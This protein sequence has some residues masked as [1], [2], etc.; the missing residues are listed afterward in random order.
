MTYDQILTLDFIVKYGS[1]KAAA[2][3]MYKSQPS[4]SM[5]IKKLEDEFQFQILSRDNYR[6]QLTEE[7]K[8]FYKKD[9][10]AYSGT[11]VFDRTKFGMIYGSG[12]FFKGLGDKMIHNEVKVDF[13]FVVK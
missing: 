7:G 9:G 1:F 8:V 2:K 4:L 3:E 6:P 11:L 13:K 12:D 10:K 5:A